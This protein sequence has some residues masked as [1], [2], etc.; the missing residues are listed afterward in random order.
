MVGVNVGSQQLSSTNECG[1]KM[2]SATIGHVASG[3][4]FSAKQFVPRARS[5][6]RSIYSGSSTVSLQCLKSP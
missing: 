2:M 1:M 3:T 5:P 6:C 4:E